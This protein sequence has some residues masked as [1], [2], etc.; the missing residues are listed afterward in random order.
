MRRRR[1]NGRPFDWRRQSRSKVARRSVS[2]D[3]VGG[4]FWQN[5]PIVT[6]DAPTPHP[7]SALLAPAR[8]MT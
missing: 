5:L 2:F 7:D 1:G 8:R 6:T 3:W 4:E